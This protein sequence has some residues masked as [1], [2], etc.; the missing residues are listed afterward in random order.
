MDS[1]LIHINSKEEQTFLEN[2]LNKLKVSFEK[3]NEEKV[4]ISAE[5]KQSILK[6]ISQANENQLISSDDVR[7]KAEKLC[8][9]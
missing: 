3:V 8:S 6:G 7:H 9:K 2:L 1:I 4:K 5:Q